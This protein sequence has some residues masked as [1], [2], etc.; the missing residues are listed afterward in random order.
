LKAFKR[1][2]FVL[3]CLLICFGLRTVGQSK[4]NNSAELF[5]RYETAASV[6][7]VYEDVLSLTLLPSTKNNSGIAIRV[8]SREPFGI[9]LATASADPF[10]FANRL[11]EAFAYRPDQIM[12]LKS[13]DCLSSKHLEYPVTEIWSIPPDAELPSHTEGV[14]ASQV[15]RVELGKIPFNRG[16]R[17][18]RAAVR[19][20]IRELKDR[21]ATIGVVYGYYL[22]HPKQVLERRLKE[23]KK[24]L[25]QSGLPHTRYLVSTREWNDEISTYPPDAEPRYPTVFVVELA[26]NGS[27]K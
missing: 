3:F 9:A 4:V 27:K 26:K 22:D 24:L 7:R 10:L 11:I 2:P 5:K 15:K 21:P 17:D 18:Y 13:E 1:E 8:C 6:S 12:F 16:V 14:N 20:L 23:I 19:K 25:D